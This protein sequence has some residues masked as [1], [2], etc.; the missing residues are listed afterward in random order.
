MLERIPLLQRYP[1]MPINP[2]PNFSR[3]GP[4][5]QALA[6]KK[7]HKSSLY[8]RYLIYFH[9][10]IDC[11]KCASVFISVLIKNLKNIHTRNG[12]IDEYDEYDQTRKRCCL[13]RSFFCIAEADGLRRQVAIWPTRRKT[14]TLNIK[15][16]I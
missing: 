8:L 9:R 11:L 4:R 3:K 12:F 7:Q 6:G 14:R 1:M 10:K 2:G 16:N 5:N 15:A 13:A